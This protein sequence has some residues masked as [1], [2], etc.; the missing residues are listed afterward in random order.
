MPPLVALILCTT[1][2][3]FLLRLEKHSTRGVSA[4]VWIPTLWMLMAG[5]RSLATWFGVT[6]SNESGSLLDQIALLGLAVLS[7]AVL[8]QRRFDWS[9]AF[10]QQKWLLALLAYMFLSAFWS[11]M[12]LIVL[13]RWVREAI[14]VLM[15]LVVMSETDPREAFGSVLRRVAYI[16]IPF[17]VVLIKYYPS[18]GRL[19]GR[20]SGLEMWTGVTGQKNTLGRLCMISILF[21]LFALWQRWQK[22]SRVSGRYEKWADISV[23][24]IAAYLLKGA[25]SSTSTATLFVGAVLFLSLHF[26]RRLK[27]TV[28]LLGLSAL[29]VF[30]I[31][32]G[33]STP[34]LGGA[35]VASVSSSLG[36]DNTLTGRTEV[37]AAVLPAVAQQ[38]LFGYGFGSFWTDARRQLYDI[39]TAHNG[40]L[41]ILLELGAVGLI[42]Y[43]GW[44]LSCTRQLHR[45]LVQD[46]DWA[47]LAI[48]FLL[49][50]LTYNATE[51]ALNSLTEHMTAVVLIASFVVPARLRFRRASAEPARETLGTPI[52]VTQSLWH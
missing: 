25:D 49:M 51:S 50:G 31:G 20:W 21:L 52:P 47:S 33:V 15:A 11:D 5:S 36:R 42:F 2:V 7:I 32:F 19:Y 34:L 40:Y 6:G 10:R 14:V 3:L 29:V 1:F 16:L 26:L 17:S 44:L 4:A 8:S 12:T 43:T 35:T 30:L 48:C 46:Y 27:L 41:D 18:L 22:Q 13:K 37:W 28:P 45:A 9:G 24:A 38:P 23:I 39:P